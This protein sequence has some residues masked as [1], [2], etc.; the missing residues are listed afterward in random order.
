[1]NFAGE[2][3][4]TA[5]P[6]VPPALVP[7]ASWPP[8]GDS[9][10]RRPS[11]LWITGLEKLR[12]SCSP[13]LEAER[14]VHRGQRAG[15]AELAAGRRDL[16]DQVVAHATAVKCGPVQIAVRPLGQPILRGALGD[17]VEL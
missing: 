15:G 1:M 13:K 4:D 11:A 14:G 2:S 9:P 7:S 5:F 8:P 6:S 12:G 3:P 10:Y 16:E 17:R